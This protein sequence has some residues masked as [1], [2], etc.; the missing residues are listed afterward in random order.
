LT[1]LSS[2][3]AR[4]ARSLRARSIDVTLKDETDG[5]EALALIDIGDAKEVYY[6]L[7][8]ALK[9]EHRHWSIFNLLFDRMWRRGAADPGADAFPGSD[10]K[11]DRAAFEIRRAETAPAKAPDADP[12]RHRTTAGYSPEAQLRRKT[13]DEC[14]SE[15]LAAMQRLLDR[16]ARRLATRPSRRLVP[17]ARGGVVDLRRSFRR[18][19]ATGGDMVE[20]A[21]RRR[22][23]ERPHLVLLCDTSG[24][25][26][27]YSRFLLAFAVSLKRVAPRTEAFAFNTSLTRLTRWISPSNLMATLELLARGVHDWSGGTR[28]GA[29]L[30]QFTDTWLHQTVGANTTIII[31]S[32]G[33]DRG[34]TAL[35]EDA[36]ARMRRRARRIIWLNPLAGDERYR[37][38]ARGMSAALPYI[39]NLLPAHNL[40]ALEDL[41]PLLA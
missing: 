36:L 37:P 41:L 35:L 16:L 6:A 33:L 27:S 5:L 14:T 28:I 29:S 40:A 10:N 15:D 24:S 8:T 19:L 17:G 26:D 4:F 20:L 12:A 30:T 25:M 2:H 34:D 11:A 18:S 39:D 22:A 1:E 9:I 32:D 38:E 21:R 23:V 31:V 3:V 7:R 13:F